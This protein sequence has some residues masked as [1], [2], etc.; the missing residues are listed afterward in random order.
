MRP[1]PLES[2]HRAPPRITKRPA[3]RGSTQFNPNQFNPTQH[4]IPQPLTT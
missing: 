4:A 1:D 3:K 2:I